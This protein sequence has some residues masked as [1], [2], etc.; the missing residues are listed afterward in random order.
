MGE[1]ADEDGEPGEDEE[2]QDWGG[3]REQ[4]APERVVRRSV[5]ALMISSARR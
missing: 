3:Q 1:E 2:Q 4:L 5:S